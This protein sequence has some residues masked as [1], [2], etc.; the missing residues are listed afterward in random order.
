MAIALDN[1]SSLDIAYSIQQTND[2]GYIVAGA[3]SSFGSGGFNSNSWIIKLYDNGSIQWQKTYGGNDND[4]TY[5]IQ[6]TDDGGYIA[7]GVTESFGLWRFDFWIIK[8]NQDGN[9]NNCEIINDTN[10]NPVDSNATI[11]D[12]LVTANDTNEQPTNTSITPED[13]NASINQIC[14][15]VEPKPVPT[16]TD[17]G[18]YLLAF[19]LLSIAVRKLYFVKL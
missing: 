14:Y 16:M 13:T 19:I 5:S 3:T 10:I 8:L 11:S 9:I 7:A 17:L 1:N 12:T 6:Q 4:E 2:G 15:Y 18:I